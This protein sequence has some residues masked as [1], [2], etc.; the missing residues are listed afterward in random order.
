MG[1][2]FAREGAKVGVND[3]KPES[4]QN[5]VTEIERAGGKARPFVA[6]VSSSA[7]VLK[8]FAEFIAAFGTD[9]HPDQQRGHRTG[10]RVG[11]SRPVHDS[12]ADR[13]GLAQ[14]ARDASRLDL[15]LHARGA[16]GDDPEAVG[17][18]HQYG[19]DRGHHRACVRGGL[20]RGE[21]RDHLVHQVG[22]AR[23]GADGNPGQLHRAG[24]YRHADDGAD[25]AARCARRSKRQRL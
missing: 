2:T 24:I 9:R 23:S 8:M 15:L 13:R 3:I 20:L 16:Q 11:Q 10:E 5:V 4:A 22:R 19:I 1:L 12:S 6:D 25:S 14:D 21:G 18:H 7:A 17:P